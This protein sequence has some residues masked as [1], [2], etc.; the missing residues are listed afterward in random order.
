MGS[1]PV[2]PNVE[3]VLSYLPLAHIAE[4]AFYLTGIFFGGKIHCFYDKDK[5]L[6]LKALALARPTL[7]LSVPRL[8]NKF[9][10]KF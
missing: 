8:Y 9:Y 1:A 3:S 5:T 10:A 6:L 2:E 4:R 7:F